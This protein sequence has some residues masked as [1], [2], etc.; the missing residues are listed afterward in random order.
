[1]IGST[2]ETNPK[3]PGRSKA[4]EVETMA[5]ASL[6]LFLENSANAPFRSPMFLS[7][8]LLSSEISSKAEFTPSP[9]NGF[10][11]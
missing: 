7:K 9:K 3:N 6:A 2:N 8:Q 11:V 1:M 5:L 4:W 10:T